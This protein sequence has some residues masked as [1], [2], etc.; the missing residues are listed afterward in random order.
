[1]NLLSAKTIKKLLIQFKPQT[2]SEDLNQLVQMSDGSAGRAMEL[3]N[4]G[5]LEIYREVNDILDM[6]PKIDITR[7]HQ[8]GDKL[9]RD[10][11]GKVS[12]NTFDLINRWIV[13]VIKD[14]AKNKISSLDPWFEVWDNTGDLFYK[15]QSLNLDK[16]QAILNTFIAIKNTSDRAG[17]NQ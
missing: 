9:N 7:I 10:K 8:L 16:K 12:D 2:S 14:I 15:T 1:L 4:D 11:S 5:G 17:A 6:M 13:M 3:L